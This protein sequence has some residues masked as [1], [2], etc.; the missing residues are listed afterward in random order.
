MILYTI[1]ILPLKGAKIFP[2]FFVNELDQI[3]F[4]GSNGSI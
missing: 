3:D 2:K 1:F 4:V